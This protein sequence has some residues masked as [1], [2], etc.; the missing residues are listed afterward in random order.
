MG[1]YATEGRITA[2][3]DTDTLTGKIEFTAVSMIPSMIG[4]IPGVRFSNASISNGLGTGKI[5]YTAAG[6]AWRA[7][8]S[9]TFGVPVPVAIDGNYILCDGED[10]GKWVEVA[11]Y[12]AYME[13][14][15]VGLVKIADRFNNVY[16]DISKAEFDSGGTETR[17]FGLYNPS[18]TRLTGVQVRNMVNPAEYE[19]LTVAETTATTTPTEGRADV[20]PRRGAG[21]YQ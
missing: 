6:L 15:R 11:A 7:P 2:T 16:S 5:R 14:G 1:A 9:E 17:W 3:V 4:T 20:A 12:T 8:G 10:A 19:Q 21:V 13:A 18:L